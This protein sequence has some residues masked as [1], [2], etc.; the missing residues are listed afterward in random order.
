MDDFPS[1]EKRRE[2]QVKKQQEIKKRDRMSQEQQLIKE[3]GT[4]KWE[5]TFRISHTVYEAE[6]Q[7]WQ[8]C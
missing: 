1:E 7:R 8:S 6:K 2:L 5:K 4:L 3:L